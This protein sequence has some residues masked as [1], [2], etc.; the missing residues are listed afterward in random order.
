MHRMFRLAGL[1]AAALL[2]APAGRAGAQDANI[3]QPVPELERLLAAEFLLPAA[4]SLALLVGISAAGP[5]REL[6]AIVVLP[7]LAMLAAPGAISLRRGA[8]AALDWYAVMTFTFFGGLVWVG[9]CALMLGVPRKLAENAQKM[10]PGFVPRFDAVEFA[11]A[12]LL[13]LAWLVFLFRLPRSATRGVTRWAAGMTLLWGTFATL[14]MPWADY[15]KSY[16]A[17]ALQL[18]SRIPVGAG[19][20]TG[21]FLSATHR[22]A[23]SYHVDLVTR[24]YDPTRPDACPLM[25]VQGR[26]EHELDAPGPRWDKLADVTRP[27]DRTERYRLYRLVR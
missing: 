9:Y 6:Y 4:T 23:L 17:V 3:T 14:Y 7:A 5:A 11:S 15:Q 10:A 27:G 18:K 26:P 2:L 21:R 25:L 1:F 13:S 19:C 24:P 8:A 16:R 22:A 20:V 12:M